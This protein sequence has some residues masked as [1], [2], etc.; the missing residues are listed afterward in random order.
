MPPQNR[1]AG[2]DVHIFDA[3]DRSTSIG[4]LIITAGVTNANLYA[5][6]EIFVFFDSEYTLRN[7]SN[8]TIEKDNS[9]LLPGNYFIDAPRTSLSI[10]AFAWLNFK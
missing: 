2:R 5:M 10:N 3:S 7:E 4:G 9:L 8:I 6:V 1:S